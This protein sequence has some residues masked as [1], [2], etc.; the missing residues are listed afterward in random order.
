MRVL[1]LCLHSSPWSSPGTGDAGGMN[2]VVRHTCTELATSLD[3]Q[4]L[5]LPRATEVPLPDP[6]A[7]LS[8]LDLDVAD[9]DKAGLVT[10]LDEI[11]DAVA[12]AITRGPEPDVILAHYWLSAEVGRRVAERLGVPLVSM[13]HT[14]AARKNRTLGPGEEREPTIRVD[15]EQRI[16]QAS[17]AIIVNTETEAA[18]VSE[19]LSVPI[20]RCHIV[21]PGIDRHVFHPDPATSVPQWPTPERPLTIGL[22]GRLQP[23][24][25]PQV[26]LAALTMTSVPARAWIIGDGPASFLDELRAIGAPADFLGRLSPAELADRMRAADLWAV[27]SSSETFGLVAVEAQAC[28]TPVLATD[29]GGL[30][31]A[32][33]GGW[34]VPDRSPTTWARAIDRAAD[35][36]ERAE[37]AAT[38]L[39]HAA[40]LT[41]AASTA[42]LQAVLKGCW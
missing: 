35:P 11:T 15:A 12:A 17:A 34:L 13:F 5:T 41:W 33:G 22:A 19:D 1:V 2:V 25:G 14:T 29:I 42:A 7:W 10:R 4:C 23:L 30:P 36:G 38:G 21:P 37:R 9:I 28:G 32:V 6:P 26:L 31:L 27:P 39:R 3:V 24:K 8:E 20:D 18:E 40:S 16:A